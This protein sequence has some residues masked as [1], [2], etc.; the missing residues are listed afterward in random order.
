MYDPW[1]FYSTGPEPWRTGP[2][3]ARVEGY[4]GES[5][6]M[7]LMVRVCKVGGRSIMVKNLVTKNLR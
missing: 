7:I 4:G 2:F 6:G 3:R 5:D 1:E